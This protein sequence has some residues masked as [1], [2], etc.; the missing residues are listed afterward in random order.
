MPWPFRVSLGGND[1]PSVEEPHHGSHQRP[2]TAYP[3]SCL[4][5]RNPGGQLRLPF[6]VQQIRERLPPGGTA[7]CQLDLFGHT[8]LA[9]C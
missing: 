1:Q 2:F 9:I 7:S 3:P 4:R 6:K 5:R 8:P